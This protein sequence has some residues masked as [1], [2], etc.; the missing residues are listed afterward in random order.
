MYTLAPPPLPTQ[1]EACLQ[2]LQKKSCKVF[3]RLYVVS[4]PT[5][6]MEEQST[7]VFYSKITEMQGNRGPGL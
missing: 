2:G 3:T 5:L 6:A 1:R 4:S 7:N